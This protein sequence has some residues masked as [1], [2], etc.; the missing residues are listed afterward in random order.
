MISPAL[1]QF[2]GNLL[3]FLSLSFLVLIFWPV[4]REEARYDLNK[5]NIIKEKELSPP[6]RDFSIII[7]KIAAV[8]PIFASIDSQDPSKF[9]PV[10]KRGVAHAQGS[11]LPGQSGN[12]YLFAHS[13]DTFYNVSHYN[14]VF[15]LLGKLTK[16]DEI[17]V[18]YQRVKYIYQVQGVK[19]VAADD[20]RYLGKISDKKTLTLQTCYP[21]GT[22]L[23]R[24]IVIA[25]LTNL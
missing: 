25:E 17:D 10:L 20:T 15:Y 7:P 1:L 16:G 23:K 6:N 8:A 3:V 19:V 22:T 12:V 18:W 4:V 9:L 24:L 11:V 5:V 2:T 14:A 13:T 21:P